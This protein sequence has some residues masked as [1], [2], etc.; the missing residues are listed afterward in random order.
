MKTT[1]VLKTDPN[2]FDE[3]VAGTKTFEIRKNYRD[4]KVG[5]YLT[6]RK[7]KYSGKEIKAGKPLEYTGDFWT[8]DVIGIMKGPIYGLKNGWCIMSIDAHIDA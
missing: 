8:V 2:V 7:T 3:V 1:H 4:F 6:L 5:D